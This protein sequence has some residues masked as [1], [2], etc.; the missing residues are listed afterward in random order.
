[1]DDILLHTNRL[2]LRGITPEMYDRI[3]QLSDEEIC[4]FFGFKSG[5]ELEKERFRYQ[6]GLRTYNKTFLYFQ[7]IF[8]ETNAFLGWCGFHTWY[9]DH[10]RAEIGYGLNSDTYKRQGIMSEAIVPIINFGFE[11]M[12]LH[13]I[14]AFV[15]PKNIPSLKLLKS[16]HFKEEGLLKEHYL[17]D[18]CYENSHVYARLKT[19]K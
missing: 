3:F 12:K 13:R 2:T 19:K 17:V 16:N 15:S 5:S 11:E 9:T 7:L 4:S 10:H 14:E 6:N 1:M 8:R 18:G